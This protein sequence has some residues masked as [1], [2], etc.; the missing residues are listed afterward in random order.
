MAWFTKPRAKPKPD[1]E[2]PKP[3]WLRPDQNPFGIEVVDCRPL[4][5]T[6]LSV[7]GDFEIASRFVVLRAAD[8]RDHVATDPPAARVIACRL[9]YPF[10]GS[11]PPAGP[12]FKA[13]EMEDKWD[14]Y[15]YD[16]AL[17]CARSWTGDLIY[18]ARARFAEGELTIDEMQV[19]GAADDG[20]PHA[21]RALDFLIKSH[22]YNLGVPHPLPGPASERDPERLAVASLSMFGRRAW[23]GT[24]E[25]TIGLPAVDRVLWGS[26]SN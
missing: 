7:T 2:R 26:G 16:D 15:A 23:F 20:S 4:T 10:S 14:I 1:A 22:V 25:E 3:R 18:A 11:T 5:Q 21:V 9:R 17:Y 6:M 8:G 12:L 13:A 24:Y 19:A